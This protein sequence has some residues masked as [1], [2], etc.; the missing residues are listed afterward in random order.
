MAGI[1][2]GIARGYFAELG[3]ELALEPF[4]AGDQMIP[5]LA[6]GQID[7][8]GLGM[9]AAMYAA[10]ARGADLQVVAG[11]SSN[12]PSFS[13]SALV[14]RKELIDAGTIRELADLRGRT[15]GVIGPTWV[16]RSMPPGD[17]RVPV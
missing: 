17:S 9:S 1:Y 4:T 16:W 5:P 15:L 6:T 11:I 12:Q 3:L 14:V 10:F 13:S 7:A 8:A 2:L